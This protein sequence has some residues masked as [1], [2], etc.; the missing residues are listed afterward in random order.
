MVVINLLV[1]ILEVVSMA[2]EVVAAMDVVVGVVV[3][4]DLCNVKF[5]L[6]LDILLICVTTGSIQIMFLSNSISILQI[7]GIIPI[8]IHNL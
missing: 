8:L 1:T 6:N 2:I 5:V 4:V 7:N 3:V